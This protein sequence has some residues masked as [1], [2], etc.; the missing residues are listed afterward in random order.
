MPDSRM[1]TQRPVVLCILD[2]WGYSETT[3]GNA[4]AI[5]QTPTWNHLWE[6][7]PRTLLDASGLSVGLPDGQMGNSEVG[8]LTI[9]LGQ[10]LM[11]ELPRISA[12]I[13]DGSLA[14]HPDLIACQESLR[15]LGRTCHIFGLLSDGGVHAHIDH[16]IAIATMMRQAGVTVAMHAFLDGRD[17]PPTS[18][19]TYLQQFEQACPGA[20]ATLSGRFYA[21][22]RDQRWERTQAAYDAI[23]HAQAPIY[24]SAH[25]AYQNLRQQ[26]YTDEFMPPA[27]LGKYAGFRRGDAIIFM[28]YRNDRMI[29]LASAILMPTWDHFERATQPHFSHVLGMNSLSSAL[30]PWIKELFPKVT[31]TETLGWALANAGHRQLRIAETEK[32]AHVTYFLNGGREAPYAGEDR[33]MI[34]SPQ[35]ALYNKTPEMSAAAISQHVCAAITAGSHPVI[36]VNYANADMVGHTGDFEATVAA[37][38]ALDQSLSELVA[39]VQDACGRLIITADHGNAEQMFLHADPQQQQTAHTTNPVPCLLYAPADPQFAMRSLAQ[40][41]TLADI[42]PTLLTLVGAPIPATMTG[43]C[44]LTELP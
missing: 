27:S 32:Y 6:N 18:A 12:A 30:A 19:S 17:T 31:V 16:C 21:M 11:Q 7:C 4:I 35:V 43:T 26:G 13:A 14:Q 10:A 42:A 1:N 38:E 25:E 15:D 40:R 41:G 33:C 44:L 3:R 9:G 36:I 39:A 28:N 8:H 23:V 34:S 22:D 29:Q 37:I 2:G 5:A 24:A 20:L